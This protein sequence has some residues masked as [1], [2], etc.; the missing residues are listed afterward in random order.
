VI[1]EETL[2]PELD[3]PEFAVARE[4]KLVACPEEPIVTLYVCPG[5]TE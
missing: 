3:V 4:P 1:E 2:P 5:V